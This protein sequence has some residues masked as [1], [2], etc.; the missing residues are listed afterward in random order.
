MLVQAGD[1][2]TEKNQHKGPDQTTG[3]TGVLLLNKQDK[4]LRMILYYKSK[5]ISITQ[6]TEII[7]NIVFSIQL[8]S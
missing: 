4:F 1:F 2:E 3:S 8:E 6:L 5:I 7:F